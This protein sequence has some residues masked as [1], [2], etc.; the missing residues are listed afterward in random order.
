MN[1]MRPFLAMVRANLKMTVR[2]RQALFWNLAFPAIFILIFGA[3]FSNDNGVTFKVG[4]A[5]VDSPY[6]AAVIQTLEANKSFDVH[7]GDENKE[8]KA[9]KDSDR[10]YVLVFGQ[11]AN[12]QQV[13]PVEISYDETQGPNA[14]VGINVLSQVLMG[15]AGGENAAPITTRPIETLDITY[16]DF[17]IPGILAM[18]I[19]NAGVIGL[20]TA[21]VTYREKGI[22]RRIKVTPFSLTSFI[23]ARI[24]TTLIVAVLQAVVLIGLGYLV[25]GFTMRGNLFLVLITIIIGSLAFLAIGFALSGIARN[26]ETAASY[27]NL[28]TFP[29]LFLSGTFFPID[30]L[31]TWLQ[32]LTRILPLRYLIDALRDPMMRGLGIAATWTD[33]LVLL[34]VFAVAMVIA[35]RFFKWDARPA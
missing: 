6:R 26:T 35:V 21:F 7:V 12:G 10:D 2:N 5:G 29:M 15:V 23:L 31:P 28:V 20:S 3:V 25:Y 19:M 34:V 30:S 33:L 8:L 17:F 32:G 27:A 11:P 16:I 14:Q 4:I 18:S 9:H 13:A 24:A 22:L 1:L